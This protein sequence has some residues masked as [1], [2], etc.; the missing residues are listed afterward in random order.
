MKTQK[1]N[2]NQE[3]NPYETREYQKFLQEMSAY[4]SCPNGVCD[5]VLAGG[6]CESAH[7]DDENRYVEEEYDYGFYDE[8]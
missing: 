4:C 7:K 3:E 8:D 5:A 6:I 2:Q 1:N